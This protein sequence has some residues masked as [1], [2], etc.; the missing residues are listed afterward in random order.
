M[1]FPKVVFPLNETSTENSNLWRPVTTPLHAEVSWEFYIPL[2][3]QHTCSLCLIVILEIFASS[4]FSLP[5]LPSGLTPS[6]SK[7]R[8][9]LLLRWPLSHVPTLTANPSNR[10]PTRQGQEAFTLTCRLFEARQLSYLMALFTSLSFG[11][12]SFFFF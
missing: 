7:V 12:Y 11:L 1:W 6:I 8:T 4:S 10:E 2:C 5:L 9:E 3:L